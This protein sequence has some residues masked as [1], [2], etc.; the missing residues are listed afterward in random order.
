M[1]VL[2]Y[3]LLRMEWPI[4]NLVMG[5]VLGDIMENRLRQTLSLG[6]GGLWI[7]LQRPITLL[8]LLLTL[9]VVAVPIY[10]DQRKS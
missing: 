10:F 8:I 4:V 6:D 2:G 9:L 1:G 3:I 5:V 7:M